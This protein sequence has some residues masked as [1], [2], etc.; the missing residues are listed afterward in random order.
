[1]SANNSKSAQ[2]RQIEQLFGVV[3]QNPK[4]VLSDN[5]NVFSTNVFIPMESN[6]SEKTF[7]YL[8]GM[9]KLIETFR[10]RVENSELRGQNWMLCIYYDHM[11]ESD[12]IDSIYNSRESNNE[13]NKTIKTNY[14]EN[15]DKLKLLLRLYKEYLEL[16]KQNENGIYSFVK[17][18]SFNCRSLKK[19][20]KKG[21]LGHPETFGSIVRF[22]PMFNPNIRRMFSINISHALS[23]RLCYLISKWNESGRSVLHYNS[24]GYTFIGTQTFIYEVFESLLGEVYLEGFYPIIRLP[25]GLFGFVNDG[26][27]TKIHQNFYRIMTEVINNYNNNIKIPEREHS[28]WF[29][30]G[31]D[32]II[33]TYV[34]GYEFINETLDYLLI[35]S[36]SN[37]N[38]E[39]PISLPYYTHKNIYTY[40]IN[41]LCKKY[42]DEF[43]VLISDLK[44]N[45]PEEFKKLIIL[46]GIFVAVNDS[47]NKIELQVLIGILSLLLEKIINFFRELNSK[48]PQE[49]I[50]E[51]FINSIKYFFLENYYPP[52]KDY[53]SFPGMFNLN[54]YLLLKWLCREEIKSFHRFESRSFMRNIQQE[55]IISNYLGTVKENSFN[56]FNFEDLLDSFDE[57]KP[58]VLIDTSN[59]D[60]KFQITNYYPQFFTVSDYIKPNLIEE[61]LSYYRDPTKVLPIPYEMRVLPMSGGGT[62]KIKNKNSQKNN[63][64]SKKSKKSKKVKK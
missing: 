59:Q 47:R 33:L 63:K 40:R 26:K 6:V 23:P 11:F 42:K 43:D 31:I 35:Q 27:S 61:L 38:F 49:N 16:I 10:V 1:M 28:K 22:L 41:F 48:Y 30:Y 46:S 56:N 39:R 3:D 52:E 21:Y 9:V 12:Y 8:S 55:E 36:E 4:V 13:N 29:I 20:E 17:L 58:L 2:Y 53:D 18:Y 60:S 54:Y 24:S 37:I 51:N 44:I 62:K 32:E 15:K 57:E 5:A 34:I 64:K 19:K 25:A 14:G 45:I 7:F 50:D